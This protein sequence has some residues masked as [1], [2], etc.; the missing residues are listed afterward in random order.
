V[1]GTYLHG[2]LA[3]GAAR[4]ALLGWLAARAGRAP[5]GDWGTADVRTSR[6]DRLADIVAGAIDVAAVGKLVGRRL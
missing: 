4:R 3:S 6:W 1:V 5:R 2:L